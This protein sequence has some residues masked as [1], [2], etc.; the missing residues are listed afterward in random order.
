MAEPGRRR[1]PSAPAARVGRRALLRSA[2][3]AGLMLS[4]AACGGDDDGNGAA[5]TEAP[6]EAAPTPTQAP[7][8]SPV[9]GYDV[10]P[11]RW[12]GRTLTIA[13][14]GGDYQDAQ[15]AA[16]FEPF[17]RA[18]GV[19]LQDR[20]LG[21]LGEIRQQVE[22]AAVSFDVVDVPTDEVLPLARGDYL[23]P[24]DYQV[25]D[26]TPLFEEIAMQHGVGA[27]F[28]STVIGYPVTTDPAPQGWRDFWDVE[29]FPGERAVRESPF[30]TLEF[31]LLADGVE[32]PTLYPLDVDR[33]FAAL[34]RLRPHVVQWYE[35]QKQPVALLLAGDV[36]MTSTFNVRVDT[37]EAIG[38]VAIQW[39]GGM[40]GADSWVVP[41][42][43]E[44]A[45]IAMDFINFA[46]RAFPTANF[47][48]LMPFGPVNRDALAYLRQD[49]LDLM[50]NTPP[51]QAVQF[52]QNWAWWADNREALEERFQEWLQSEPEPTV[53][54]SPSGRRA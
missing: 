41:N 45:D 51:R 11:D 3:G 31:A 34:D 40:L 7:I 8:A 26:R 1:R 25:V 36:A 6:T 27:A 10:N 43:A 49:R 20:L 54:P 18:T 12:A 48:R 44:N 13:S 33:A 32:I 21:D 53:V 39:R 35:N 14:L 28:F 17:A 30:G 46:T 5:E 19:Q 29:T 38:Q 22:N 50:P 9:P 15:A 24:I 23:T 42:G 37:P 4:A 16:F 47:S 2:V 52:V